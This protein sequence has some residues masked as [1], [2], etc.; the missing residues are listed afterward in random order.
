[1]IW[2]KKYL[3]YL[4]FFWQCVPKMAYFL[5]K[6]NNYSREMNRN[7]LQHDNRIK[8][9]YSYDKLQN[10]FNEVIYSYEYFIVWVLPS[11]RIQ[12]SRQKNGRCEVSGTS[13]L[14]SNNWID[15]GVFKLIFKIVL[16][17]SMFILFKIFPLDHRNCVCVFDMR[18]KYMEECSIKQNIEPGFV[19]SR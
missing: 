11:K 14:K 17:F 2:Q 3:K 1:M 4:F 18:T 16:L 5:L 9:S 13:N 7:N 12:S 10:T 8:A 19:L 6:K 15:C